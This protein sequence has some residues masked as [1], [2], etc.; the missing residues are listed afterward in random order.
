MI[1]G[2]VFNCQSISFDFASKDKRDV[3]Q[4]LAQKLVVSQPSLNYDEIL[5]AILERENKLSTGIGH[6][7][8]IP[9]ALCEGVEGVHGFVGISREGLD[10]QS[11]DNAPVHAV[12]MLVSGVKDC[13]FHLQVIRRLASL[14]EHPDFLKKFLSSASPGVAYDCIIEHERLAIQQM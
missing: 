2:R 11:L 9:H 3:I 12:F 14:I 5:P 10:F 4:E 8:A 7:V 1:L 13:D 6:G